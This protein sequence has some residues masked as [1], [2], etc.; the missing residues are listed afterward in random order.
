MAEQLESY[1]FT[2][3]GPSY[4]WDE[5]LNGNVWRL[6]AGKDFTSKAEVFRSMANSRAKQRGLGLR[7]NLEKTGKGAT[8]KTFL[9]MQAFKPEA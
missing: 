9:V 3:G 4:P 1:S 5:W 7:T 8:A 6:T 2:K